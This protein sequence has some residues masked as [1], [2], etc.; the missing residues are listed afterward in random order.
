MSKTY[1]RVLSHSL[2]LFF[3]A[4]FP[5]GYNTR[6]AVGEAIFAIIEYIFIVNMY[7]IKNYYKIQKRLG[8]PN[9]LIY[10]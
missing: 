8:I 3:S 5:K 7:I 9:Q 4:L 6:K 10:N 1:G 2:S